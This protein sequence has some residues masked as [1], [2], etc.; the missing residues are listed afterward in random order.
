MPP[1]AFLRLSGSVPELAYQEN[2]VFCRQMMKIQRFRAKKPLISLIWLGL[3]S[4]A[5]YN[6]N[7]L[8]IVVRWCFIGVLRTN[9]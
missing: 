9:R 5:A 3:L 1:T 7:N 8:K 2:H 6:G 4:S